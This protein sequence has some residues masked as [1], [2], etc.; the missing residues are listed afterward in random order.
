MGEEIFF[1]EGVRLFRWSRRGRWKKKGVLVLFLKAFA[2]RGF[3]SW[4]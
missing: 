2:R 4:M 1:A 3:G